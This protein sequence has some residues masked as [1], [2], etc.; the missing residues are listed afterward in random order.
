MLSSPGQESK[1]CL[2]KYE[3]GVFTSGPLLVSVTI[4]KVVYIYYFIIF[5]R[6]G[7]ISLWLYKEKNMYLLYI[8]PPELRTLMTVVLTLLTHPRKILSI[9]LQIGK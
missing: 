9:M 6:M 8:F 5:I 3:A 7:F 1:S 4:F 2:P